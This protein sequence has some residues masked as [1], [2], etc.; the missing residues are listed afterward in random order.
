MIVFSFWREANK[1]ADSFTAGDV[2][3]LR[4]GGP[5]MTVEEVGTNDAGK[6][7]VW[8]IWFDITKKI[9][10]DFPAATLKHETQ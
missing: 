10:G 5:S 2:V 6:P 1:M 7:T 4:S 9:S 8:C 3:R